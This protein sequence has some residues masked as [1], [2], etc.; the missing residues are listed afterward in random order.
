MTAS[1][2]G[3]IFAR[4]GWFGDLVRPTTLEGQVQMQVAAIEAARLAK[5]FFAKQASLV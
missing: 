4:A 3:A 1:I 5:P 2:A